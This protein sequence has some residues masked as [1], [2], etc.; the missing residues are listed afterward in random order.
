VIL[1][2]ALDFQ[3]RVATVQVADVDRAATERVA[4]ISPRAERSAAAL[5]DI[6]IA[7]S[8]LAQLGMESVVVVRAGRRE[9]RA[10]QSLVPGAS[11]G[12]SVQVEAPHF[13]HRGRLDGDAV[14]YTSRFEHRRENLAWMALYTHALLATCNSGPGQR[15]RLVLY[16]LFANILEHG[17]PRRAGA[18]IAF[19]LRFEPGTISGWIEDGC[20]P[21]D[22]TSHPL[23]VLAAHA[24]SRA[25]RGYGLHIVRRCLGSLRH[26]QLASGNRLEFRME[27]V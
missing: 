8:A 24:G 4:E 21:F 18:T 10:L 20:E 9:Q 19:E 25:A 17:Q 16:E 1:L 6:E 23:P 3:A 11:G 7:A 27:T 5:G 22:P 15:L 26:R 14:V 13:Q 2:E 12:P